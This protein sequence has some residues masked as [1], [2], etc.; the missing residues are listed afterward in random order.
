MLSKFSFGTY[1]TTNKDT[2]HK[3]ALKHA[4][5]VGIRDIDTSSNYM[6]GDAELLIADVLKETNKKVKVVSKGGYIQGPT[7]ERVKNG[8]KVEDLVEYDPNCF[9]SISP[10][11]LDDQIEKSLQ[12]L[13]TECIDTYLLHNP[14][15]YLMA[16]LKKSEDIKHHQNIMQERIKKAFGTLEQKVKEGKIKNYGISSNSFAKKSD[17]KYF[18]E[19]KNLIKHAKNIAGEGHHLKVLQLPMNLL[20]TH[21]EACAKWG[22]ENNLEIHINR[23]LNAFHPKLGMVRLANYSRCS[24]YLELLQKSKDL[25]PEL[26]P[27]ITQLESILTDFRWA[28]DIDDTL[29]YKVIP[30]INKN[31]TLNT[32]EEIDILSDFL[33]CYKAEA[34]HLLSVKTK[35]ELKKRDIN[36][37]ESIDK[38]AIKYLKDNPHITKI[39]IGMRSKEYV[40]RV[41]QY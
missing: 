4:I 20:E 24:E 3:E 28:G 41:L 35:Y 17:D 2:S 9:H 8:Y 19:Y 31:V 11:F 15:Y 21:G 38:T 7:L 26:T 6:F 13:G 22:Y 39:L 29:T 18:L 34:K 12:R 36:V 16:E 1:R 37:Q 23:P 40:D 25:S 14:E 32:N 5:D 33:D 10:D 30:H 27:I